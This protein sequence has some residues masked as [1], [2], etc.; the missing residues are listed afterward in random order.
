MANLCA[1]YLNFKCFG[2]LHSADNQIFV[3]GGTYAFQ[4]YATLNWIYHAR[5]ILK[6]GTSYGDGDCAPL[7]KSCLSM[8]SLHGG[9]LS[10]SQQRSSLEN[11]DFEKQDLRAKLSLLQGVYDKIHSI[12]DDEQS[13]GLSSI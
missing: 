9:L 10:V 5:L 2:T 4:E 12:S 1:Q 11:T 6:P 8:I 7:L 13:E 3:A